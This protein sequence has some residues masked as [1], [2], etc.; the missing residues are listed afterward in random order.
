[1]TTEDGENFDKIIDYEEFEKEPDNEKL[2]EID[3]KK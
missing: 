3:G 2:E 1:M